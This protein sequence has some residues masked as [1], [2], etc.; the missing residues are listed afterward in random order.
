[1]T[2][3]KGAS[4]PVH[5]R[6]V[7]KSLE[8]PQTPPPSSLDK[9]TKLSLSKESPQCQK[10]NKKKQNMIGPISE[11][12]WKYTKKTSYKYTLVLDLD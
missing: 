8:S 7:S 3:V 5:G 10:K 12:R 9:K 1:M 6:V 2:L 4:M 11:V